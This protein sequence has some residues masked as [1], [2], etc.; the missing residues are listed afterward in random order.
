MNMKFNYLKIWQQQSV[1]Q[2]V[3]EFMDDISYEIRDIL[4]RVEEM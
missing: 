2:L 1:P 3:L 4:T